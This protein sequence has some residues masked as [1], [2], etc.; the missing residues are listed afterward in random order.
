MSKLITATELFDHFRST[1][2]PTYIDTSN[3]T[4]MSNES[5]EFEYASVDDVYPYLD[6]QTGNDGIMI[7]T[8]QG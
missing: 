5:S 1:T 4:F 2:Q 8:D 3:D 6:D 7:E